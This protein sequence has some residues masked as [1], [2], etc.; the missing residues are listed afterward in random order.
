MGIGGQKCVKLPQGV[1]TLVQPLEQ[2]S[3][4]RIST[5]PPLCI[6]ELG[7]VGAAL[8]CFCALGFMLI[9][10]AVK[11]NIPSSLIGQALTEIL[12]HRKHVQCPLNAAVP[13][14]CSAQEQGEAGGI[15]QHR[16][17]VSKWRGPCPQTSEGQATGFVRAVG[18]ACSVTS[19]AHH[20]RP[21]PGVGAAKVGPGGRPD[22]SHFQPR[23]F[24]QV[25]SLS[26]P[27]LPP[28]ERNK[29][30]PF[31]GYLEG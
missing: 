7:W 4:G 21:E 17:G 6:T 2:L 27:Q 23:G 8:R 12:Q 20:P 10:S 13:S 30:L 18:T 1:A 24:P 31:Q 25:T 29:T 5:A 9:A 15:P 22:H 28:V 14:C 11:L 3:W 26:K 19:I 16:G